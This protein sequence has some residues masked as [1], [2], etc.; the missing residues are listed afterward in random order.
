MEFLD[1]WFYKSCKY[2]YQEYKNVSM[3]FHLCRKV[4]IMFIGGFQNQQ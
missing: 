1:Q 2:K 3:Y 4:N